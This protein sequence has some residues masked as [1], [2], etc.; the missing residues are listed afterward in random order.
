MALLGKLFKKK[1]FDDFEEELETPSKPS[2]KE[3]FGDDDFSHKFGSGSSK[4]GEDEEDFVPSSSSFGLREAPLSAK[5]SNEMQM[6]A[7]NIEILSSKLDAI[8]SALETMNM[9]I[10]TIEKIALRESEK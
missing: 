4:I 7:K 2:F 3:S 10:D 6:M 9:K 8:K 1:S 5:P